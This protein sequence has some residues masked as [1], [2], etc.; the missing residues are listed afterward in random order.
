MLLAQFLT[1]FVPS[2]KPEEENIQ[3]RVC[4]SGACLVS[5]QRTESDYLLSG[6]G[7]YVAVEKKEAASE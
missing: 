5:V 4:F 1:R 3:R 7:N 2:S 6:S